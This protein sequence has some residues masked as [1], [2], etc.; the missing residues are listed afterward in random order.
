MPVYVR[1]ARGVSRSSSLS[2]V[3]D[4]QDTMVTRVL[5]RSLLVRTHTR[6][7]FFS[8]VPLAG[9]W[10]KHIPQWGFASPTGMVTFVRI[11]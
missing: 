9:I 7:D 6:G 8:L 3:V 2:I 5:G 1:R 4:T 11:V 10:V